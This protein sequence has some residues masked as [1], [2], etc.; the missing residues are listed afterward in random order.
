MYDIII[1]GGGIV[2]LATAYQLSQK[3]APGSKKILVLEKESELAFHQT[4]HNSGVIHSG[5]YY[6]PGSLRA[7]NCKVGRTAMVEFAKEHKIPHDVCGKVIVATKE[8]E[9]PYLEE[10]HRRGVANETPGVEMINADQLR[11]YEPHCAGIK[12][13]YVSSAGI[14]NYQVVA[15]KYAELF[16]AW[17]GEIKLNTRVT[18][19]N[20][21]DGSTEVITEKENFKTENIIVCGG[22]QS[23]RLAKADELEPGMRIVGF[24][25]EYYDL[26]NKEKVKNLIYPVPDPQFPWLGVHFTRM[27]DGSVECGPNAVYAFKRDGYRKTDF[28]WKDTKDAVSYI[29]FWKLIT[30]NIAYGIKEQ[31]RSISKSAFLKSLQGLMPSLTM[32]DIA[33]GRAGVRALALAPDGN[34]FDDFKFVEKENAIHV[35]NAPSPAATASL[36]V[37]DTIATMAVER[38]ALKV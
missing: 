6:K 25:G 10:I 4:G 12:A 23:D 33:P 31:Y 30:S 27:I 8:S 18:G 16:K 5:V 11:E 19:F 3:L 28:N 2:G 24:R 26:V 15:K 34:M 9:L 21:A 29:G 38:F 7:T 1:V 17:G 36:S 20:K 22:S 35:L 14:I 37:G 13:V 32:E